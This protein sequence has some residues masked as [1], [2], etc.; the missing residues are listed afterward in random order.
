METKVDLVLGMDQGEI[1]VMIPIYNRF[2]DLVGEVMI[3]LNDWSI[4][5]HLKW[6]LNNG[7][8]RNCTR[9]VRTY[10]HRLIMGDPPSPELEIDHINRDRLDNRRSNLR[11]ATSNMNK[12]N[13]PPTSLTGYLGI[14]PHPRGYEIRICK[15]GSRWRSYRSTLEEAVELRHLWE[16]ELYGCTFD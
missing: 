1:I 8:V 15:A 11:W 9:N 12:V 3:D 6:H 10:M 4:V 2:L 14:S 5:G 13:R 7:Y 16:T